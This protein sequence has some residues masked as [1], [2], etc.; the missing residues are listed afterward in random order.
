MTLTPRECRVLLEL[1]DGGLDLVPRL[2]T[3]RG[4]GY[5]KE[6]ILEAF[7]V[8]SEPV[9]E[10]GAILDRLLIETLDYLYEEIAPV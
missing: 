9:T 7:S 3:L 6:E 1:V 5:S 4:Q 2:E 8:P 10:V